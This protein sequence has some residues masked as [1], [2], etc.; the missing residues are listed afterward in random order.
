L[1][2][3]IFTARLLYTSNYYNPQL[4]NGAFRFLFG[5]EEMV[6]EKRRISRIS[7]P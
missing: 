6:S 4:A 2:K 5:Q 7:K 1:F 3:K